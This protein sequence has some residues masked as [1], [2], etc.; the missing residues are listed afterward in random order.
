M[1][2]VVSYGPTGNTYVDSVLT[3]LKWGASTLTFSFPASASYYSD[4]YASGDEPSNN[5]HAFTDAQQSAVRSILQSYSDVINVTFVETTETSSN[6]ADIRY[7]ESNDPATAWGYYPGSGKGGDTWFNYG[8][9]YYDDPKPGNYAFTAMIHETGHAMGLKHPHEASGSFAAMPVDHDSLEYSVMSYRSYVGA[10]T[11]SGY[12]NGA[13]SYPQTL[14]MYDI[15]ALQ[16]M[17]GADYSTH[18]GDTVYKWDPSTGQMSIDGSDQ[19]KPAGNKVFM[20]L[21]DGGGNDTYDL[22]NYTGNLNVNLQPGGWTTL[23]TTQLADLGNGHSAAGNVANALLYK[24]NTA[25]LIENVICGNGNDQ[26][27]GN[28]A[29]N[30]FTGNGGNDTFYGSSGSDTCVYSGVST[31]Y[32]YT[33]TGTATWIV[34][35]HGAEGIDTLTGI[36]YLKF[37]D[38]VIQIGDPNAVNTAPSAVDDS[39]TTAKKTKLTVA[40]SGVLGNDTDANGDTL[41]AT[42]PQWAGQGHSRLPQRRLVHLHAEE[43]LQRNGQLH[44]PGQ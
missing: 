21:W 15:A 40:A 4:S 28:A 38:T 23:S 7:A 13:S 35:S 6:H 17:Y 8:H 14:M 10:S 41:S 22:S 31:S 24:G 30:T 2:S 19:A 11:S 44:L 43:T 42:A 27:T 32:T 34:D 25:S 33:Q 39:Y 9:H 29:N 26:V 20:T 16:Q 3:G 5:F 36:E 18:S 37:A 12:T 1:T